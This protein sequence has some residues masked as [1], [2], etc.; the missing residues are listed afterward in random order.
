MTIALEGVNTK[1]FAARVDGSIAIAIHHQPAVIGLDPACARLHA[2]GIVIE[3]DDRAIAGAGG[4][5]AI[6][7]EIKN[8]RVAAGRRGSACACTTTS[9]ARAT[10]STA[11]TAGAPCTTTRSASGS[12]AS[13]ATCAAAS[14]NAVIQRFDGFIH[15]ILCKWAARQPDGCNCC[16]DS[17]RDA[18]TKNDCRSG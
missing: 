18:S 9:A 10:R 1:E 3:Q 7:I 5:D 17:N 2:I 16:G 14:I 6:A 12:S 11:A 15:S 8:Q 13:T 4:F